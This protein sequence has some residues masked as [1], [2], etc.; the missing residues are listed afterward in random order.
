LLIILYLKDL[1][2]ILAT[3][4]AFCFMHPANATIVRLPGAEICG[5]KAVHAVVET[6]DYTAAESDI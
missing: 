6:N 2:F 4:I 5:I 1:H 3:L